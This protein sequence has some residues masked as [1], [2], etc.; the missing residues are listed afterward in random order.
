M[1]VYRAILDEMKALGYRTEYLTVGQFESYIENRKT[2][3]AAV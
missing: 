2:I 1:T 3:R